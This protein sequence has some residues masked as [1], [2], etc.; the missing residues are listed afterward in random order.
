MR[1]CMSVL[2]PGSH[3]WKIRP[4]LVVPQQTKL[5]GLRRPKLRATSWSITGG[6]ARKTYESKAGVLARYKDGERIDIPEHYHRDTWEL[7]RKVI[8]DIS[9]AAIAKVP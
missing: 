8:N 9:N 6:I 4:S 2:L 5:N 1:F 7:I 3:I